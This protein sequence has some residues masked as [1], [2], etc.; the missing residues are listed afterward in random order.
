MYTL[1]ISMG[2]IENPVHGNRIGRNM[3]VSNFMFIMSL[4][5]T[6]RV[7]SAVCGIDEFHTLTFYYYTYSVL[8][9]C[10]GWR[11]LLAQRFCISNSKQTTIAYHVMLCWWG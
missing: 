1:S 11:P 2:I 6:A 3:Q 10:A 8:S 4:F 7:T 9:L 5:K